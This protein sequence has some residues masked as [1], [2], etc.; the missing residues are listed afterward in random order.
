MHHHRSLDSDLEILAEL[1][2]NGAATPLLDFSRNALAA[3][4]MACSSY[5]DNDGKVFAIDYSG[6][7]VEQI[8]D[9]KI[10][11][12]IRILLNDDKVR[13]WEPPGQNERIRAQGSFFL[14]ASEPYDESKL[15][16][17]FIRIGQSSKEQIIKYLERIHG[18]SEENIYPDFPGFARANAADKPA[19]IDD[20]V[21]LFRIARNLHQ[22]GK[23]DEAISFYDQVIDINA[24]NHEAYFYRGNAKR[25]K[26]E[27]KYYDDAIK[28]YDKAI[29]LNPYYTPA[30]NN[31]GLVRYDLKQYAE[32]IEDYDKAIELNPYYTPA[33]NNCGNAKRALEQYAV[34]IKYYDRAIYLN[35]DYVL[36]Y[37]NRGIVK[38][39]LKYYAEAIEDYDKAIDLNPNYASAY[40]NRGCAFKAMGKKTEARV[41]YEKALELA[42]AQNDQK[43]IELATKNLASLDN[44]YA[45]KEHSIV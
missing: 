17:C 11:K 8:T 26:R 18:L 42:K 44:D 35:K 7:D 38:Y 1:Q 40:N 4:W 15:K 43:M 6:E 9:R 30:Y 20:S 37:S 19:R 22:Q 39:A 23:L 31:R 3:L 13:I 10:R 28:D 27:L 33:Y 36:A 41:D 16:L 21:S 29:E 14:L 45:E 34:A 5:L 32:A 24:Q 2:H 12:K 25:D